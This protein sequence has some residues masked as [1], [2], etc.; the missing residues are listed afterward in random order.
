MHRQGNLKEI[1]RLWCERTAWVHTLGRHFQH[2]HPP[3]VKHA[4]PPAPAPLPP[5]KLSEKLGMSFCQ[6]SFALLLYLYLEGRETKGRRD[7]FSSTT[8]HRKNIDSD[9]IFKHLKGK[10]KYPRRKRCQISRSIIF[11][12][13][14]THRELASER[15]QNKDTPNS[16]WNRLCSMS[17]K[18]VRHWLPKD[19]RYWKNWMRKTLLHYITTLQYFHT[20][21]YKTIPNIIIG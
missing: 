7:W 11:I 12:P 2:P 1:H 15:P 19:E 10:Q 3:L 17:F 4:S 21:L 9:G 6:V 8:S 13:M 5:P 20:W 14:N 16:L 18:L